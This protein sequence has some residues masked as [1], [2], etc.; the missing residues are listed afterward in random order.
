MYIFLLLQPHPLQLPMLCTAFGAQL[1]AY[2][3][4]EWANFFF[5]VWL[6][7]FAFEFCVFPPSR[8]SELIAICSNSPHPS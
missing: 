6:Y 4:G 1:L 7:L 5:Q 8:T 2:T 3:E